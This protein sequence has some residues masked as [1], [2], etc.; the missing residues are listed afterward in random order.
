[1]G[2]TLKFNSSVCTSI[3]QSQRLLDLG[4][5][6]ETADMVLFKSYDLPQYP[7]DYTFNQDPN[8]LV[9]CS[10]VPMVKGN[11][12]YIQDGNFPAWS[13]HRLI[14]FLPETVGEKYEYFALYHASVRYGGIIHDFSDSDNLYDNIIDCIEWLIKEGYISKE[15]LKQ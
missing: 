14:A 2:N 10:Y 11:Q 1:M 12:P 9:N 3:E 4:L 7:F 8:A 15:Y 5:K 13:L 6:P